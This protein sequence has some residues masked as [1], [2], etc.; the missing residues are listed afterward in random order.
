MK[1]IPVSSKVLWQAVSA[2][3]LVILQAIGMDTE[4]VK[5]LPASSVIA[6][7]L[8]VLIPAAIAWLKKDARPA[9]SAAEALKAQGWTPPPDW[10]GGA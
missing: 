2:A 9:P 10:A 3:L 4:W 5:D 1:S 7:V 6:P 8:V